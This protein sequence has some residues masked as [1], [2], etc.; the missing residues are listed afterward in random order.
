MWEKFC[1]ILLSFMWQP[2]SKSQFWWKTH[3]LEC[4]C[5]ERWLILIEIDIVINWIFPKWCGLSCQSYDFWVRF[6][7]INKIIIKERIFFCFNKSQLPMTLLDTQRKT[8]WKTYKRQEI[9]Y[10]QKINFHSFL[11]LASFVL[12]KCNCN[13][14]TAFKTKLVAHAIQ[15]KTHTCNDPKNLKIYEMNSV[16]ISC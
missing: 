10:K 11:S 3:V 12:G 13:R 14:I 9:Y 8:N 15:L 16:W 4:S 5:C 2:V 6:W 7:N 1:N